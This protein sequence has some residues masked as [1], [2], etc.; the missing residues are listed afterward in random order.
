[1]LARS[2]NR[3]EM[4]FRL[5]SAS[6]NPPAWLRWVGY[7]L[8]VLSEMAARGQVLTDQL[9]RPV[10]GFEVF[11]APP[12]PRFRAS[13]MDLRPGR[14]RAVPGRPGSYAAA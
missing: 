2:L 13:G 1:M 3:I 10:A 5:P 12:Y 4:G 14:R 9:G 8:S 6:A 11:V 7:P